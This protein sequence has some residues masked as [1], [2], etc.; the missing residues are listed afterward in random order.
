MIAP[1]SGLD[2]SAQS[3]GGPAL[4]QG[5][6]VHVQQPV[7]GG[8]DANQERLGLLHPRDRG[9]VRPCDLLRPGREPLQR[10][11]GAALRGSV[12]SLDLRVVALP[13][14]KE[15]VRADVDHLALVAPVREVG[16][17]DGERLAH[18]L[19][20]VGPD[21]HEEVVGTEVPRAAQV[22]SVP[23]I[24][25]HE[26]QRGDHPDR[27]VLDALE[28]HRLRRRAVEGHRVVVLVPT[29]D[30]ALEQR[31]GFLV[32]DRRSH[33]GPPARTKRRSP[34]RRPRSGRGRGAGCAR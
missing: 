27:D 14:T 9:V 18:G 5:S 23:L 17:D 22:V 30:Q 16:V 10:R 4:E 34:Q 29:H 20:G 8:G 12:P 31:S 24:E 28:R 7:A 2:M 6:L 19:L 3:M 25:D 13:A 32:I 26:V 15:D 1:L 21:G 33:P 11:P